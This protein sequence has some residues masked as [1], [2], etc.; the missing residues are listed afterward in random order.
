M[1]RLSL[2]LLALS[3]TFAAQAGDLY[4]WVDEKGKVHYT[5]QPPPKQKVEKIKYKSSNA[6][7]DEANKA[8]R[9]A[10]SVFITDCGKVCDEARAFM[11]ARQT[12]YTTRDPQKDPEEGAALVKLT[13]GRQVPILVVGDN[14]QKGFEASLWDK[15][16]NSAG[17]P[18]PK[19]AKASENKEGGK[20]EGEPK[21]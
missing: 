17:Y 6:S 15:M 5:D 4:R 8:S 3:F 2:I 19:A 11:S 10:V 16:L 9:P 12:P 13:G 1:K 7:A 20:K 18:D 14:I 21:P